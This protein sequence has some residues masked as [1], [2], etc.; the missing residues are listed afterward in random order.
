MHTPLL[1]L[2]AAVAVRTAVVMFAVVIGLRLFGKRG[3][4]GLNVQDLL[5]VLVMANAVQNS[6][7]AGDGRLLV[8]F[9]SASTL[10]LL[11]RGL[12]MLAVRH[13]GVEKRLA[14]SPVILVHDGRVLRR[15]AR[16]QGVSMRELMAEVRKQGLAHM[17][18]V[19]L[20]VLEMDGAI[21]IVPEE[22]P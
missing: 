12:G 2:L 3:T 7:T 22:Q 20:A 9:V 5:M 15:N 17:S 10:I 11:S 13:P 6:M 14:G 19:R 16:R 18:R 21:S 8:A 4:G 1:P